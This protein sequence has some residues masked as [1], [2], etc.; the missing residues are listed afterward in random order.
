M[1]NDAFTPINRALADCYIRKWDIL[2]EALVNYPGLS[3]PYLAYVHPHYEEARIRLVVIGKETNGWGNPADIVPL[4]AENAVRRQMEEYA[5]FS[6]GEHYPKKQAFWTPVYELY[7]RLNPGGGRYGFMALNVALMDYK[8]R[9]PSNDVRKII[10]S[11]GLLQEQIRILDPH[12]VVFYSGPTYDP[13]LKLMFP[14]IAPPA[15]RWLSRLS[16]SALPIHT[17]RT[18]HPQYLNRRSMRTHI[19]DRIYQDFNAQ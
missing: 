1:S 6:L 12:I 14:D 11:T 2:R 15:D 8:C 16:S 9:T 18:Y 3:T 5:N 13:W 7:R 17:Y 19:H 4:T 10:I